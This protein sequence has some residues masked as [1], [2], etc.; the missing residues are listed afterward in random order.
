M[1]DG[2][3]NAITV[4]WVAEGYI[5]DRAHRDS[6][7]RYIIP[8]IIIPGPTWL[9]VGFEDSPHYLIDAIIMAHIRCVDKAGTRWTCHTLKGL[10]KGCVDL[11]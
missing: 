8:E 10:V 4:G 9:N 7:G 5:D 3:E 2:V 1:G 11:L 6:K